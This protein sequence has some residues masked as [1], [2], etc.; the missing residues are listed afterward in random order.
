MMNACQITESA[1]STK[2]KPSNEKRHLSDASL[3]PRATVGHLKSLKIQINPNHKSKIRI[4]CNKNTQRN[5]TIDNNG[6]I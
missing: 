4:N 5:S 3:C 2:Q 1:I 6:L